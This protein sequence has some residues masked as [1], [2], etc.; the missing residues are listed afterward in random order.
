MQEYQPPLVLKDS[1]L[2]QLRNWKVGNTYHL[3][4]EVEQL[5][6]D[7]PN[8]DGFN[9]SKQWTARF[10]VKSVKAIDAKNDTMDDKKAKSEALKRLKY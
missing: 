4:V 1:Q 10:Q 2:P 6:L 7:A 9:D 8:A 3:M 5:S